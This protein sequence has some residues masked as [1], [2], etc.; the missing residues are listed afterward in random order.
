MLK[1][2]YKVLGVTKN[3]K[4]IDDYRRKEKDELIEL[5]NDGHIFVLVK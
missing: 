2:L 4:K 3:L 1:L 5:F